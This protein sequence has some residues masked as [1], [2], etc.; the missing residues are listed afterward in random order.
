MGLKKKKKKMGR[1]LVF[2]G[3]ES[4]LTQEPPEQT[5]RNNEG[6]DVP[7]HQHS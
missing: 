4:P 1:K 7:H 5:G 2:T 3:L 6:R